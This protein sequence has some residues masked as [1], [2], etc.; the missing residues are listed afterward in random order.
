MAVAATVV[1]SVEVKMTDMVLVDVS[2]AT[3]DV[4]GQ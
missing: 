3:N 2:Q 1:A 4:K